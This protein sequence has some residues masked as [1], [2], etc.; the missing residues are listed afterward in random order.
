LFKRPSHNDTEAG[1]IKGW[2]EG[3][4]DTAQGEG[5]QRTGDGTVTEQGTP[6][7]DTWRKG[8]GVGGLDGARRR[9][10]STR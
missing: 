3:R 7:T 6:L 8:R 5:F 4:G 10:H 9:C 2:P 1:H